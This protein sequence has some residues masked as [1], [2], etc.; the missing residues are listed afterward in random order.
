MTGLEKFENINRKISMG[1]EWVGLAALVLMMV[2]TTLDVL[3]TKL[4]L[5]PIFGALDIMMLAQLVAMTFAVGA[6]L[7]VGLH[8]TVE[9]FVPL[10]PKRTQAVVDCSVFLL[11]FIL[12]ALIVW[13]LFLYSY[14]LQIQG[15]VSSTAQIPFYPFAYGATLACVPVCLVYL[16]RFMESFLKVLKR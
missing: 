9:F 12:F 8:V 5:L 14:D 11:G 1:I 3:G 2:V 16:T 7:I 15:E 6:T 13:R 4:F 10:L